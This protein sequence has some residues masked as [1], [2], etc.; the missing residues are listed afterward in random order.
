MRGFASQPQGWTSRLLFASAVLFAGVAGTPAAA[1][2]FCEIKATR[3]GFVALRA[4]PGPNARLLQRMRPGDEVLLRPEREG[5]W[6]SVSYWRG[7]RFRS[8]RNPD[9][10]PPTAIGW[11]HKDLV[12]P[13]SCG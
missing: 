13:D 11:M 10:D 5:A 1:T 8:G 9:G 3:D 7:G 6:Q 2:V 12:A 4:G